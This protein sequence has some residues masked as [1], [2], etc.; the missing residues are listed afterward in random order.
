MSINRLVSIKNAIQNALDMLGIDRAKDMPVLMTFAMDAEKAI[1]GVGSFKRHKKVLDIHGCKAEL[2]CNVEKLEAAILGLTDCSCNDIR[3][4]C[5]PA[6]AT[7]GTGN[8]TSDTNGFLVIDLPSG[9]STSY[10]YVDYEVQN[11]CLIFYNNLDGKKIAVQYLGY[12]L[13]EDEFPLISENHVRAISAYIQW[14]YALR[15]KYSSNPLPDMLL[16]E[17][18]R[19]WFRLASNARALDAEL[20][21]AEKEDIA[22]MLSDNPYAGRGLH[23]GMNLTYWNRY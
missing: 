12:E 3:D 6:F 7:S 16:M 9:G 10:S 11:N 2:P 20:Q 13:G 23:V 4:F 1:G 18:K 21:P 22:Q 17:N 14:Q 15:S 5:S 19:E 8:I